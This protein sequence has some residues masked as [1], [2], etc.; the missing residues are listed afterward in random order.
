MSEMASEEMQQFSEEN[1][2][3]PLVC[4]EAIAAL[5]RHK[6]QGK[7]C[8]GEYMT[9]WRNCKSTAERFTQN[10]KRGGVR[11]PEPDEELPPRPAKA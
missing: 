6:S 10:R 4:S 11:A 3:V 9:E 1:E 8:P 7:S 5:S 2:I